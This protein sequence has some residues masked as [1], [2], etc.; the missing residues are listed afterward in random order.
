MTSWPQARRFLTT[1]IPLG[2]WAE[3]AELAGAALLLTDPASSYL[4]GVILPASSC[5]STAAGPP[6]EPAAATTDIQRAAG[7]GDGIKQPSR[8]V[9]P[10]EQESQS[11]P[12]LHRIG[13]RPRTGR[14]KSHRTV[15]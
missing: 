15:S 6:T 12:R 3:P 11:G 2:R 9:V 10:D 14:V 5:P 8:P 13:Q 7:R 4:T 1:E